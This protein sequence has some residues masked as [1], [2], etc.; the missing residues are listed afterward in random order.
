[1]PRC[2]SSVLI[3]SLLNDTLSQLTESHRSEMLQEMANLPALA[4][5]TS[6]GEVSKS[7]EFD[8]QIVN[9]IKRTLAKLDPKS[10]IATT[11]DCLELVRA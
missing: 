4:I 6:N 5:C 8:H 1:M 9:K 2:P 10:E 3:Q 7:K 11:N